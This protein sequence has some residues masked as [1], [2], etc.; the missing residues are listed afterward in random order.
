MNIGILAGENNAYEIYGNWD[1]E[2]FE[3]M[4]VFETME[5]GETHKHSYQSAIKIWE[6]WDY[7]ELAEMCRTQLEE[8][9]MWDEYDRKNDIEFWEN[10]RHALETTNS[11]M[12]DDK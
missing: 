2:C 11:G 9:R 4:Y 10:Y 12:G 7:E 8:K 5:N 3:P 1:G 6:S